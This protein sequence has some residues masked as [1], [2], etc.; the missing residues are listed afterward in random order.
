MVAWSVVVTVDVPVSVAVRVLEL[1]CV[2]T[3]VPLAVVP[4][5][6]RVSLLVSVLVSWYGP[7]CESVEESVSVEQAR[8]LVVTPLRLEV[9]VAVVVIVV[10]PES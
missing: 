4:P 9:T 1:H 3:S 5:G 6:P 10:G 7:F 8:S 2:W